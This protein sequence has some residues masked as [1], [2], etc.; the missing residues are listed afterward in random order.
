MNDTARRFAEEPRWISIPDRWMIHAYYT[1]SPFAPDGSG[2]IIA[3]AADLDAP[4]P[5]GEVV[6]LDREGAVL[7]RFGRNR[8]TP[9][10]WHTGF[11]QCFGP[12]GALRLLPV[13]LAEGA[14][15]RASRAR[16]RS[17][18]ARGRRHGGHP[19]PRVSRAS[20][21]ATA[22]STRRATAPDGTR[23]RT[24]SSP[25]RR[26]SVT[27][28]PRWRS[29]RS[30]A[31]ALCSVPPKYSTAILSATALSRPIARCA[32]GSDPARDSRS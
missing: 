9:S 23:R 17:R 21:A 6:I 22:S 20:P 7:E 12:E 25:S 27:G 18:G 14:V 3:A 1:I 13:G 4:E 5:M 19:R 15:D 24:R 29:S 31:L 8:V 26:A 16:H 2:R 32:T 11:W 28:S 30:R 10:F